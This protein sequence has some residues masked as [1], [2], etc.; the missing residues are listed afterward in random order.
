MKRRIEMFVSL[1]LV[2]TAL[3][4]CSAAQ[5]NPEVYTGTLIASEAV[6]GSGAGRINIRIVSYTS[7][8]EKTSLVEAFKN[9]QNEGLTRLRRMNKGF[10]NIEGQ[11]GRK[12]YAVLS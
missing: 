7:D 1:A 12:V 10:I 6:A 8:A 11:P 5:A 9:S 2:A 4:C 3:C